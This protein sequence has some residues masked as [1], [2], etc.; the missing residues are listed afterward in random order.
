MKLIWATAIGVLLIAAVAAEPS[1]AELVQQAAKSAK[2]AALAGGATPT[3]AENAAKF[4]KVTR[5]LRY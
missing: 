5:H 3:Q 4:A 2:A 1:P